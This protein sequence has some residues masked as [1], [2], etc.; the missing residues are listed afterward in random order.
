M[1]NSKIL[2]RENI[3]AEA[4]KE[5]TLRDAQVMLRLRLNQEGMGTTESD[6][7]KLELAWEIENGRAREL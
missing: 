4:L 5:E 2:M 3:R 6:Y 1:I 7:A